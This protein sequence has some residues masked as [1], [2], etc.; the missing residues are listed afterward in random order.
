MDERIAKLQAATD[1]ALVQLGVS[2]EALE[3]AATALAQAKD[4]Y[5]ALNTKTQLQ[6]SSG[7][8]DDTADNNDLLMV[9]DTE[10]PELLDTHHRA[11]NVYD[12]VE[13]RYTTNKRYLEALIR[14]RDDSST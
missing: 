6:A 5:R 9:N 12:T 13:K 10:L 11:Q 14:K 8:S 1:E 3:G 7:D 4:K 2:K